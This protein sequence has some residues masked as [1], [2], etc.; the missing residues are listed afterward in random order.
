LMA[1][2]LQFPEDSWNSAE[3]GLVRDELMGNWSWYLGAKIFPYEGV[4]E[5]WS[6]YKLAYGPD[7]QIWMDEVAASANRDEDPFGIGTA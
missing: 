6:E 2:F 7:F 1:S 5:W 4:Q 3:V